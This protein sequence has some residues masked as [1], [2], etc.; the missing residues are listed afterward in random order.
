MRAVPSHCTSFRAVIFHTS[1]VPRH[2]P[3]AVRSLISGLV[4]CSA[5]FSTKQHEKLLVATV[6]VIDGAT[7]FQ[8]H[9]ATCFNCMLQLVF[10]ACRKL[11]SPHVAICH[12]LKQ[13]QARNKSLNHNKTSVIIRS[14]CIE[15]IIIM[16]FAHTHAFPSWCF[17]ILF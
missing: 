16:S 3:F 17:D 9:A 4:P 7:F 15:G 2:A 8:P 12:R 13:I 14:R 11:F 10:I 1:H 6:L 5:S